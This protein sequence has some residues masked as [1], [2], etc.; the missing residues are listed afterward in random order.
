MR[1]NLF[2][3]GTLKRGQ[4]NHERF[5][6]GLISVQEATVRGRLYELPFGFPALVV[7]EA[8]VRATGTTNYL[9]DAEAGRYEEVEPSETPSNWDTVR[10]ELLAFDDPEEC[11][12]TL[13]DLEVFRPGAKSF[14]RRVLIPATLLETGTTV[15]AWTYAVESASGLYLPGGYW[16]DI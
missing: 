4:S 3:Y 1:L 9:A 16:P 6:Q 7:L 5:C 2:V 10:G 13:D 8:D 14:Y 15:P 11:L 12:P